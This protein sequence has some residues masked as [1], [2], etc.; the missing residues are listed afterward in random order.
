MGANFREKFVRI[1][2]NNFR[3][4]KFCVIRSC[5]RMMYTIFVVSARG[6]S[7]VS[8]DVAAR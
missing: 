7:D 8:T 6:S 1:V 5:T 4:S 3:G 2:R